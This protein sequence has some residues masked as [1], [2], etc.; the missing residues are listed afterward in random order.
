MLVIIQGVYMASYIVFDEV[1]SKAQG[2]WTHIIGHFAPE[3]IPALNKIGKHVPCPMHGGKDGFRFYKDNVFRGAAVCN[4]CGQFIDAIALLMH[5]KGW[6]YK[7]CM[8]H[9]YQ[10]LGG[11]KSTNHVY[12]TYQPLQAKRSVEQHQLDLKKQRRLHEYWQSAYSLSHQQSE[13]ARRYFQHRAIDLSILGN[14]DHALR[15]LPALPYYD[16]D[17]INQGNFPTLLGL[18]KSEHGCITLMRTFLNKNGQ[19]AQ[20]DCP[21]KLMPFASNKTLTGASIRLSSENV[22]TSIMSVAEG[23]ETALSVASVTR[24]PTWSCVNAHQLAFV[25]VPKSI[26][27]L[28]IW[29]D[30]DRSETGIKVAM[31][32][33]DRMMRQGVNVIIKLPPMILLSHQKGWDWNDVLKH[34][35]H[36]PFYF[37]GINQY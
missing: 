14:L 30:L 6:T 8:Q 21:K 4:T 27:R 10:Y 28:I 1:K 23:I 32:L 2:H 5:V 12:S 13:V 17:G 19:K 16:Q 34:L 7:E 15:F 18:V 26:K 35:G 31:K 29:A 22:T 9:V 33:K 37:K 11:S 25:S 20:V 3:F 24:L 36:S